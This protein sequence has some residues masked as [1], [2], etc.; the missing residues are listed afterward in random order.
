[1]KTVLVVLIFVAAVFAQDPAAV[2]EAESAC[3]PTNTTFNVKPDATQHPT[4]KP[5]P[6]KALVY[7]IEDLGQ[8][9][10]CIASNSLGGFFNDVDNAITKVGMDGTWMGANRGSSYIFFAVDPGEHHL[11]MN[12]QSRL[13]RRSR[14]FAMA[15]FTAEEGKV[16]YFR[17]RVFPGHSGDY[18]FELDPANSD[19]GKY[20]VAISP[21]SV[22]HP[23][24]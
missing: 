2:V 16:Y 19:E 18:V 22:S 8:C 9:P 14:A 21:F 1:M 5:E 20:L 4:A 10:G 13:Q 15:N 24:K 11:C 17:E 23:K 7:L 6:G 12:W 3:G